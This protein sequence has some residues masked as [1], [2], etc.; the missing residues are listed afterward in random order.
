MRTDAWLNRMRSSAVS[1]RRGR[2]R[3]IV[4]SGRDR[5]GQRIILLQ[6][7]LGV[8]QVRS[9]TTVMDTGIMVSS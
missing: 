9:Y 8:S 3:H 5:R 1:G 7:I 6:T 2:I 4:K